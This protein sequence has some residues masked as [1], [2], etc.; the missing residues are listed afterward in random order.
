[1]HAP[2]FKRETYSHHY[3][4]KRQNDTSRYS[5]AQTLGRRLEGK[6]V[7]YLLLA[8][9]VEESSVAAAGMVRGFQDIITMFQEEAARCRALEQQEAQD[10]KGLSSIEGEGR[11]L[12]AIAKSLEHSTRDTADVAKG[13][14]DLVSVYVRETADIED[15]LTLIC[16]MLTDLSRLFN[17]LM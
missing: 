5:E 6:G 1:M 7:D 9:S 12:L 17:G 4:R 8:K 10:G 15:L 3:K 13:Y 2:S 16:Y 11:M 14:R